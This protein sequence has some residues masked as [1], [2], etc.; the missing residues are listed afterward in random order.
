MEPDSRDVPGND[1]AER[2]LRDIDEAVVLPRDVSAADA[3]LATTCTLTTRLSAGEAEDVLRALPHAISGLLGRCARHQGEPGEAFGKAEFLRRVADH[4]G[5]RELEAEPIVLAVFSALRAWLA[6]KGVE[7]VADQLPS[8]LKAVWRAAVPGL[9][10]PY[11]EEATR[12][13]PPAGQFVL[14]EIEQSEAL[15]GNV[16]AAQ[17]FAAALGTL[18]AWLNA[19]QAQRF[20]H[21]L[22]SSLRPLVEHAAAHHAPAKASGDVPDF[23]LRVAGELHMDAEAAEEL[24]FVT[25]GALHFLVTGEEAEQIAGELPA[26]LKS[27]WLDALHAGAAKGAPAAPLY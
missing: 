5:V 23:V 12:A 13:T 16:R 21:G 4:L 1:M 17:A 7:D 18:I 26:G 11:G 14:R 24:A 10:A 9:A 3:A 19:E 6:G 25:F 2:F 22:P 20:V 8:E 27:M 15:P